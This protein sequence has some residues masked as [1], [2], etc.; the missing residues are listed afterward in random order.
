MRLQ[1]R[2]AVQFKTKTRWN[3]LRKLIYN[4]CFCLHENYFLLQLDFSFKFIFKRNSLRIS[5]SDA[6][7]NI[8]I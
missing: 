5:F 4:I 7:T 3:I 8:H 1:Q 6:T 2:S